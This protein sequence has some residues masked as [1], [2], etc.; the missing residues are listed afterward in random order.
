MSV[1]EKA[2]K[3]LSRVLMVVMVLGWQ[4]LPALLISSPASA[5]PVCYPD[6]Q[7]ANEPGSPGQKDLTYLCLDKAGLPTSLQTSWNWD[8]TGTNGAN[9][10]DGCV[11][12]DNDGDGNVNYAVC[13]TTTGDPA[14]LA[15]TTV[16]SCGDDSVNRCTSPNLPI[17]SAGVSCIVTTGVNPFDASVDAVAQCTITTSAVGGVTT[18]LVDV[19]SY[20][21]GQ[22]NSDPSDCV[23][24][25]PT[26]AKLEVVKNLSPTTD[27]GLF[28]LK[29]GGI[30]YADNVGNNGTTGQIIVNAGSITI[31][32]AENAPTD[33]ATYTTTLVCKDQNGLGNTVFSS[34]PTGV[35]TRQGT[36]T[37]TAETDVL[38]VFTNTRQSGTLTLIKAVQNNYGGNALPNDFGLKIDGTATTSGTAVSLTTGA[39]SINET[40]LPGYE[41]VSITGANC[42]TVLGGNATVVNGQSTVCTIT[43]REK[44]PGLTVVKKVTNDNG[45]NNIASDFTLRV[46]GTALTAPVMSNANLTATYTFAN[47]QSNS[48]YNISEDL[49]AGYVGSAVACLDNQTGAAVANPVVLN[50]GQAV[51]CTIT[52]ND[53]APLLTLRKIVSNVWGGNNT[54]ADWTLTA[55]NAQGSNLSGNGANGVT[56]APAVANTTYSLSESAVT[57]Y[58]QSGVWSCSATTGTVTNPNGPS[59]ISMGEGANV[60]CNVTNNDIRPV[61]TLKKVIV[62]QYG[63]DTAADWDLSATPSANTVGATV[64]TGNGD[65][66]TLGGVNDKGAYSNVVY[67]LT[68]NGPAG[69]TTTGEWVC[70][71]SGFS[72]SGNQLTLSEG[73]DAECAITNV[74]QAPKLVVIKHVVND[75]GGLSAAAGF[76]MNVS[77]T[78]VSA[79]SFAGSETGTTVFLSPGSYS[80]SENLD[81]RYSASLS[82]DCVGTIAL[83]QTKTCTITNDDKPAG[84]SL[85]KQV[86]NGNGGSRIATEWTLS[87]SGPT[88][89]SGAGSVSS[90]ATFSSGTYA[91]SESG[92]SDYSAGPWNC[93]NNIVPNA[94]NQITL[95]NGQT[96]V[97]TIINSSVAPKLTLQKIVD[98]G[99]GGTASAEDWTMNATNAG[100]TMSGNGSTGFVA[101]ELLAGTPYTLTETGGP[102]GYQTNGVWS[103]TGTGLTQSANIINLGSG[104]VV[105]C[106]ITND[107]IAPKLTLYKQVINNNSGNYEA[108]DWTLIATPTTGSTISGNGDDGFVQKSVKANLSYTLG[109]Q[110]PAGY[111]VYAN[112]YCDYD[113]IDGD[114]LTLNLGDNVTCWITNNDESHPK[115]KIVKSGPVY[116]HEGETVTY[117]AD[118]SNEGDAPL[119]INGVF[120]DVAGNVSSVEDM[121]GYNV[122][123]TNQNNLLDIGEVWKG[124]VSYTIPTNQTQDVLNT[125]TVCAFDASDRREILKFPTENRA[126]NNLLLEEPELVGDACDEDTHTTDILHPAIK[127]LKSGP[128]SAPAGSSVTYTFT[129]TNTGDTAVTVASVVDSIA[130]A[131]TYVSGDANSNGL[132]D[133]NETWIYE[134]KYVIPVGSKSVNNT[135]EVCANDALLLKVCV[136]DKHTLTVPQVLGESK[137]QNTGHGVVLQVIAGM[138]VV[139]IAAF[140]IRQR[141]ETE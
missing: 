51:T 42:P 15:A 53:Q 60:T 76:T 79:T 103:C 106:T 92:P 50:E 105:T 134:A 20:P 131:G 33:L 12:F 23:L 69:Y 31:L 48:S 115:I 129:V 126:S 39:H 43:N 11:L 26:K 99:D 122:G 28:D 83:G 125:M 96:T 41:L 29:I 87:A 104:A 1:W 113:R 117:T 40:Q 21:S 62:G 121:D 16:Y 25:A 127:V 27:P 68:E 24:I 34:S 30:T 45:G 38:C 46:N 124:E 5:A 91:L 110:G 93:T 75:N 97:C 2:V 135:V 64:I 139:L 70:S 61:L 114:T 128:T 132:L 101:K 14:T 7:G 119:S 58:Q 112:W 72:L 55:N 67:T 52:N 123:D 118:I 98:N 109:E 56:S 36:F 13:V 81:S 138:S 130:G 74:E 37:I 22:P 140:M 88:S 133:L 78:N 80:V 94:N 82:V 84:L 35:D 8:E 6:S 100:I 141:N 66:A 102:A 137:L 63:F 54:A 107:D 89:I 90:G 65:P 49:L 136:D 86:N 59:T 32:E 73:A 95:V 9:S 120:D 3:R 108:A 10:L 19:C 116:A 57:G 71:G 44:A 47:T 17:S 85:V 77:G 18:S 4:I 111:F